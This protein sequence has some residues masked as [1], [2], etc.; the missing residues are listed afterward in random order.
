MVYSKDVL[1]GANGYAIEIPR[2]YANGYTFRGGAEYDVNRAWTVRAGLQYDHS[3]LDPK[4]YSPTLPD[5]SSWAGSLGATYK[6]TPAWS[7]DAGAFYAWF[8]EVKAE[9]P[10]PATPGTG[11]EPGVYPAG[12]LGA[13]T[14]Y[15][16]SYEGTFRGTYNTSALVFGL[17]LGW[18]PGAK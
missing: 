13:T 8:K 4:Y 6:F 14:V 18:T 10:N 3:G 7:I 9:D 2:N 12:S 1:T 16:P 11:I 17:S 5:A 15:V